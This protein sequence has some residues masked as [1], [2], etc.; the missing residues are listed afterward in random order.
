[1]RTSSRFSSRA[2]VG[3][4]ANSQADVKEES[5]M[6][7]GDENIIEIQ[8]VVLWRIDIRPD[9]NGVRNFLFN[10]RNPEKTIKDAA[11]AA[12]REIVGKSKFEFARTQGRTTIA[13]ET[14]QQRQKKRNV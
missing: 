3:V 1:M 11:E 7:T 9:R 2:Y 6:L 10:I 14:S 12:M 4:R 8:F 13:T 5:Q